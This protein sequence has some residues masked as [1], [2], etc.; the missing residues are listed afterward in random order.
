MTFCNKKSY[1]NIS[2]LILK[3]AYKVI[4]NTVIFCYLQMSTT[5][6]K[7]KYLLLVFYNNINQIFNFYWTKSNYRIDCNIRLQPYTISF[8]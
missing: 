5:F 1:L 2:L 7:K 6:E 8:H 4:L 3:S